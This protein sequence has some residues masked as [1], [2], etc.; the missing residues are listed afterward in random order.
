MKGFFWIPPAPLI[1]PF[2]SHQL[3]NF[4]YNATFF[5]KNIENFWV[6]NRADTFWVGRVAQQPQE[7]TR[8]SYRHLAIQWI[9]GRAF[10]SPMG[11][12]LFQWKYLEMGFTQRKWDHGCSRFGGFIPGKT[13]YPWHLPLTFRLGSR[14]HVPKWELKLLVALFMKWMPSWV[15]HDIPNPPVI[16][17]VRYRSLKALK[18]EPFLRSLTERRF[19]HRCS[20]SDWN[21][22]SR[23]GI[24]HNANMIIIK[25]WKK[26]T[27][28]MYGIFT[29]M[30]EWWIFMVNVGKYTNRPMDGMG[31]S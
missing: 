4:G 30:N 17:I 5:W 20:R 21:W 9:A 16:P 10:H 29:Y 12:E 18:A 22:M 3:V 31:Y 7:E 15:F 14:Y 25:L 26:V 28:T 27:H 8:L 23:L 13:I 2:R 19:K 1:A 6:L 24:F 11:P